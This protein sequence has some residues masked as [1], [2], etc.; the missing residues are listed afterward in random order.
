MSRP[1][2]PLVRRF[3]V[4]AAGGDR[5][6]RGQLIA[7]IND[8]LGSGV[9]S[10]DDLSDGKAYC[11]LLCKLF[12]GSLPLGKLR[13]GATRDLDC[14]QNFK[15]LQQGLD[16]ARLRREFRI[17]SLVAG[18]FRDHYELL[19]W[20]KRLFDETLAD[21]EADAAGGACAAEAP[22]QDQGAAEQG[23]YRHETRGMGQSAQAAGTSSTGPAPGRGAMPES[24]APGRSEEA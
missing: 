21:R 5:I 23:D 13:S 18:R 19:K 12:P 3:S 24:R 8:R 16:K 22:E 1:A 7:W 20:F 15:L 17:E 4:R 14:V 10:F 2:A 9:T 6:T 11:R